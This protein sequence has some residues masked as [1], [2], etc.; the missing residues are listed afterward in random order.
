[1]M[2]SDHDGIDNVIKVKLFLPAF[3]SYPLL[4]LL[5]RVIKKSLCT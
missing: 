3:D 4:I 2:K 1:M 5:Y